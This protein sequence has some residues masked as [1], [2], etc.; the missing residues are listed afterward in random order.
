TLRAGGVGLNMTAAS[1]VCFTEP[2][3]DSAVFSQAVGRVHRIGQMRPV[4]VTTLAVRGTHEEHA[5]GLVEK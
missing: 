1:N 3:L 2:C 5:L 4:R